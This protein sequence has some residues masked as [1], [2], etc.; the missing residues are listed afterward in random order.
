M[1]GST[2]KFRPPRTS[3]DVSLDRRIRRLT[4]RPKLGA[5]RLATTCFAENFVV[6]YRQ[7]YMVHVATGQREWINHFLPPPLVALDFG[8]HPNPLQPVPP[9]I[10]LPPAFVPVLD[11]NP[12]LLPNGAPRGLVQAV[13]YILP[14]HH[15]IEARRNNNQRM[16]YYPH[17]RSGNSFVAKIKLP[18]DVKRTFQTLY[19][20]TQV[21]NY[22]ST[23]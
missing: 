13:G 18:A 8:P 4:G 11:C 16:Y 23:D 10:M 3:F 14:W 5:Q 22:R 20:S 17:K 7:V 9:P 6:L 1:L 2:G 21:Q 15:R 19:W 12:G